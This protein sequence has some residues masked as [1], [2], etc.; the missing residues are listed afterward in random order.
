[1]KV[2]VV[3]AFTDEPCKGN[4]AAVVVV[5]DF[6]SVSKMQS[7]ALYMNFSE[8]CFIKHM[9]AGKFYIRWFTPTVE[10]KLCGHATLSAAFVLKTFCE[11]YG[12]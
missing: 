4:P 10:V 2:W 7:I 9:G 5:Q 11:R 8:T 3:D 6:P 12:A 1:M